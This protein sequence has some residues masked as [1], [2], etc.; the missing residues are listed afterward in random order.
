MSRILV[1]AIAFVTICLVLVSAAPA[2]APPTQILDARTAIQ[3]II[4]ELGQ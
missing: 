4:G 3:K 1:A 2:P